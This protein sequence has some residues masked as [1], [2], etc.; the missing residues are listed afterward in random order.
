M[1]WA[2]APEL[3]QAGPGSHEARKASPR[4]GRAAHLTP[5]QGSLTMG[6]TRLLVLSSRVLL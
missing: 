6:M 5:V 1:W 3:T 4:A 2:Q